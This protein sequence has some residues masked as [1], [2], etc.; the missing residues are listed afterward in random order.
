MREFGK[1]GYKINIQKW[2]DLMYAN[3]NLFEDRG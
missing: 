3:N 2:I 1:V